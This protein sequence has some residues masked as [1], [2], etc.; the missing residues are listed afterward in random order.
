MAYGSTTYT[1]TLDSLYTTTWQTWFQQETVNQVFNSTTLR[2]QLMQKGAR[3]ASSEGRWLA[4]P[5]E[6]NKNETVAFIGKGGTV[7]LADTD[8]LRTGRVEW[9]YLVGNVTRYYVDDQQ[10]RGKAQI[11][12]LM[13]A[14]VGNLR[15]SLDDH[16]ETTLFSDGS[17]DNSLACDGLGNIVSAT[18]TYA[19]FAPATYDFW[20]STVQAS[21]GSAAVYLRE[22][23]TNVFNDIRKLDNPS[24]T[25]TLIMT[26]QTS[27][28]LYETDV[29]APM[30]QIVNLNA[31]A[32]DPA[33]G[34]LNFKGVPID[35]SPACT[36]GYMYFLNTNY[37][38]LYIDAQV[39][40]EMTEWKGIPNQLDR[41]AQIVTALQLVCTNRAHQGLI[42]GIAA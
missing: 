28:E 20:K 11:K 7:S 3:R 32:A 14:K 15:R 12:S 41:V 18:S 38:Y 5:L 24:S 27:Y 13:E 19:G 26:D 1:E 4:F 34:M 33:A 25:P 29:V 9:T 35:W 40:M 2:K 17:G 37:L 16:L 31:G 22:D 39:E 23:M 6:V 8:P 42:T 21:Q 36:S 10:N 30:Q